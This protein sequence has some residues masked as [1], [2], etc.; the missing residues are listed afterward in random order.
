[1]KKDGILRGDTRAMQSTSGICCNP[2][3]SEGE[4][5]ALPRLRENEKA[6]LTTLPAGQEANTV[7]IPY[8]EFT[9]I[10]SSTRRLRC[11]PLSVAFEAIG[12]LSPYPTALIRKDW[13]PRLTR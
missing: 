5:I 3:A 1:M 7:Y 9:R 6:A 11:R 12:I 13:T 8:F 4:R 10:S 2:V